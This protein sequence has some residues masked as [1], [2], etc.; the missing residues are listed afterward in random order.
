MSG[1]VSPVKKL[2]L[3]GHL[4]RQFIGSPLTP[5]LRR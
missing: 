4:T 1:D 5:L 3:S 2:G